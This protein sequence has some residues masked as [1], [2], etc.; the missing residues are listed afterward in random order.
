MFFSPL[1]LFFAITQYN[2]SL[3]TPLRVRQAAS[4]SESASGTPSAMKRETVVAPVLA[5][6]QEAVAAK[7]VATPPATPHIAPPTP[8][9]PTVAASIAKPVAKRIVKAPAKPA[10]PAT[11]A[12]KVPKKKKR[13]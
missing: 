1:R 2:L 9:T 6:P 11:P 8:R 3:F 7:I 12:A 4:G 10:Q 13:S 5:K